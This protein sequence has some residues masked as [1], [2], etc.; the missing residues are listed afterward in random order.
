MQ[1]QMYAVKALSDIIIYD[2][3]IKCFQTPA[4]L[5]SVTC[6]KRQHS[7]Y[8]NAEY[9]TKTESGQGARWALFNVVKFYGTYIE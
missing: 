1:L 8:A 4:A 6:I 2:H 3:F 9:R 7:R 5:P